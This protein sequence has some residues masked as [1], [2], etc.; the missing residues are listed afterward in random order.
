MVKKE[1]LKKN[2]YKLILIYKLFLYIE[3]HSIKKNSY[4]V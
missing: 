1:K 3:Q 2:I 4:K